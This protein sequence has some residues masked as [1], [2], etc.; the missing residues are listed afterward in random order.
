MIGPA[1][2]PG[3][4]RAPPPPGRLRT[5]VAVPAPTHLVGLLT[6]APTAADPRRPS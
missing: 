5:V 1:A 4:R 6:V 2:L 3:T